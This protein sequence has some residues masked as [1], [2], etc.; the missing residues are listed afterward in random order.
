MNQKVCTIYDDLLVSCLLIDLWILEESDAWLDSVDEAKGALLYKGKA[1]E[2]IDT[3]PSP[4]R[5][6]VEALYEVYM[7]LDRPD[8]TVLQAVQRYGRKGADGKAVKEHIAKLERLSSAASALLEDIPTVY[9]ET[10]KKIRGMIK[11]QLDAKMGQ[12]KWQYKLSLDNAEVHGPYTSFEMQQW[13]DAGY[14]I[15]DN[16]AYVRRFSSAASSSSSSSTAA[17]AKQEKNDLKADLMD[18]SES[19]DERPVADA[20]TDWIRSDQ[21]DFEAV[22]MSGE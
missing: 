1:A 15:G 8:E 13:K 21:V 11:P 12:V 10:K 5:S 9:E 22:T 18:D 2:E 4:K 20:S 14:F 7:L 6:R 17:E 16:A 3:A 19:D